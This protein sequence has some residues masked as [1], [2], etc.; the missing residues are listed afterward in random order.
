MFLLPLFHRAFS[1]FLANSERKVRSLEQALHEAEEESEQYLVELLSSKRE[2][3]LLK[4]TLNSMKQ[5]ES[6]KPGSTSLGAQDMGNNGTSSTSSGIGDAVL[7]AQKF[8]SELKL[9]RQEVKNLTDTV[10]Q[11]RQRLTL[12]SEVSAE[13]QLEN[14][15]Q[16]KKIDL[17]E[18]ELYATRV[19]LQMSRDESNGSTTS[20]P[21]PALGVEE[22]EEEA[23]C[24]VAFQVETRGGSSV[25]EMNQLK[26]DKAE[27][28]DH[29]HVAVYR[30]DD[31]LDG[32]SSDDDVPDL[33]PWDGEG[34]DSDG[35]AN[36][37]A[38]TTDARAMATSESLANLANQTGSC[39][40]IMD[41]PD[42]MMEL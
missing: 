35:A 11:L 42:L 26:E 29:V 2:V 41:A 40:V 18:R 3:K 8:E 19:L 17:L 9:S 27:D 12:I 15:K 4:Q 34:D 21:A 30:H 36:G 13:T 23:K 5:S 1:D 28:T 20:E 10:H 7:R 6:P 16:K 37:E 31:E 32:Y 24:E 38:S 25:E 14:S 22:A 39:D 33:P